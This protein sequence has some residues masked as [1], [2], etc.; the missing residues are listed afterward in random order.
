MGLIVTWSYL[1]LRF[2]LITLILINLSNHNF[3]NKI[4]NTI[5][6]KYILIY[7]TD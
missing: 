7:T 4:I 3:R 1:C 2:I 5:Q 6:N